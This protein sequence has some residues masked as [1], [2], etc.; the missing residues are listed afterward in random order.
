MLGDNDM[1]KAIYLDSFSGA[2]ADLKPAQ[3][4]RE[5]ILRTLRRHPLVSCWDMSEHRWI[6]EAIT[7]LIRMQVLVAKDEPYPWHRFVVT[8]TG[9]ALLSPNKSSAP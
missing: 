3:R 7:E 5:N 4:S 9:D 1:S 8:A 2:L 6:R